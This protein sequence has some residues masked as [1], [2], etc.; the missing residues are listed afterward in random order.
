M[1][2]KPIYILYLLSFFTIISCSYEENDNK[3]KK[4]Y[5]KFTNDDSNKIINFNYTPNQIIIYENQFGEKLHFKVI[6]SIYEKAGYYSSSTFSGGGGHLEHY[7]DSKIIRLGIVENNANFT[8][9]QVIYIF[10][11]SENIFKNGINFPI[12]NYNNFSFIDEIDEPTNINLR[13]YNYRYRTEMTINGHIFK[14]VVIIDS[15][16][17]VALPNAW[18]ALLP[19]NVNRIYYDFNFGIIQFDDLYGKIWRVI[20]P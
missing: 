17:S 10:S 13:N 12:W 18:G 5:Y 20:Y 9:E 2:T 1:K 16:N 19:N 6:S 4:D 8:E 15:T 14:N 11:K 3:F 7:Y